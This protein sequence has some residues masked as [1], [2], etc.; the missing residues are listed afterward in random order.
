MGYI[1]V[2][3]FRRPVDAGLMKHQAQIDQDLPASGANKWEVL[4]ELAA[5]RQAFG[6]SDRDMTVLQALVSFHQATIL[7]GN[8]NDLVIFPSN[9]AICERLNG[10]PCS[11]MRR[12]LSHLVQAGIIVR[13]DSP[14]GKRYKR[15]YGEETVAYGFDLSPLPLRFAEFCAA[16]EATR[17]ATEALKRQRETVSLMRRDLLGLAQYGETVRPG[18]DVWAACQALAATT[19][20]ALRRKL[21]PEEL[22]DLEAQLGG[23]LDQARDLLD[24]SETQEMSTNESPSEQHYQNSNSDPYDLEPCFRKARGAA[25]GDDPANEAPGAEITYEETDEAAH[26]PPDTRLP[27]VPIGLVLAVC[28]EIQ[29]YTDHKIRHWHQ[30]VGA[31]ETVRPM[32]GISPSAWQEAKQ[33]MGP[34][35]ASVVVAAMLERIDDIHSPGGYLR[36]LSDK[37]AEGAFS[38]GPMVMALMRRD[39]A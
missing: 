36:S 28:A 39:Q 34:E 14:N 1:P 22:C 16:A 21:G 27:N 10:M 2:T 7:G 25:D 35:E 15:R 23:A 26:A 31:A 12:H 20:Q 19:A 5:G 6:L 29:T 8:D 9:R 32:M 4:R 24:P 30:L 3:P 17:Q 37:A 13:R 33:H 38:C 11:T 18:S